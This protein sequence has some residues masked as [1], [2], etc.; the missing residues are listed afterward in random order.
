MKC[1][2]GAELEPGEEECLDCYLARIRKEETQDESVFM[3]DLV[4]SN[5]APVSSGKCGQ[6]AVLYGSNYV[7]GQVNWEDRPIDQN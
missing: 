2:C 7:T 5:V 6:I 4:M 1:K 3:A